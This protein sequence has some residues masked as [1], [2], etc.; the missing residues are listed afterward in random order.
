MPI[1]VLRYY[2]NWFRIHE[3]ELFP[4]PAL[5]SDRNPIFTLSGILSRRVYEKTCLQ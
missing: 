1:H 3:V 2:M 5:L 4:F